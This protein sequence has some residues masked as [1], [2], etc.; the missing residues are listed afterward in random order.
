M[1][2]AR[3]LY[4]YLVSFV[5][6][7]LA[8]SGLVEVLKQ[9]LQHFGVSSGISIVGLSSMV[10]M[11]AEVD[12]SSLAVAIAYIVVGVPL[13]LIHWLWIRALATGPSEEAGAE[14]RS[15][16]RSLFFAYVLMSF[17]LSA[18][19]ALVQ[20]FQTGLL[21]GFNVEATSG[22]A[23][24]SMGD[25]SNWANLIV[26]GLAWLFF[27]RS[28][29]RDLRN[30]PVI[31]GAAAWVSRLYLYGI[32]IYALASW[33]LA[34]I[35]LIGTVVDAIGRPELGNLGSVLGGNESDWWKAPLLTA[36]ATLAIWAPI[37]L[38]HLLFSNRLL[39]ET[40]L[41]M[42][43]RVSRV[44]LAYFMAVVSLAV[45]IIA[46]LASGALASVVAWAVKAKD[47]S[48]TPAWRNL[49]VAILASLIPAYLWLRHRNRAEAEANAEAEAVAGGQLERVAF[50]WPVRV[51]DH[52]TAFAGLIFF[53]AG[54]S[55]LLALILE[56]LTGALPIGVALPTIGSESLASVG[57]SWEMSNAFAAALVGA[58]IWIPFWLMANR[59]RLADPARE[60]RSTARWYY[61]YWIAAGTIVVAAIAL[62]FGANLVARVAVGLDGGGELAKKLADPTGVV[63]VAGLLFAYHAWL[64][65]RGGV[66]GL[67]FGRAASP[68]P[69]PTEPPAPPAPPAV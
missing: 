21:R 5:G 33:L 58:L 16:I 7:S 15:I 57:R 4:L 36:I 55:L 39:R 56:Q 52:L 64:L 50:P 44:R 27:A 43:E 65:F 35:S 25:A 30:E 17:L 29:Y 46:S 68:A 61:L 34:T 66:T 48:E 20:L 42:R 63:V 49:V 23:L 3:R 45:V 22:S 12:K 59:R 24:I 28:R 32:A 38:A 37:W 10:S 53:A 1:A 60:A 51:A 9:L 2:T 14:R 19:G 67:R 11:P 31:T 41:G 40:F 47:P 13:F 6:L 26:Y 69:A 8:L 54:A 62:A 18:A